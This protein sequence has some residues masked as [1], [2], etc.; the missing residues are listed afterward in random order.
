MSTRGY[1]LST[2]EPFFA[3][4]TGEDSALFDLLADTFSADQVVLTVEQDEG[5]R[6]CRVRR[7]GP[8]EP[9][10]IEFEPDQSPIPKGALEHSFAA[11]PRLSARLVLS[12]SDGRPFPAGKSRLFR[13][14]RPFVEL[15]VRQTVEAY[16]L[17][18][19]NQLLLEVCDGSDASIFLFDEKLEI[20]WANNRADELLSRQTEEVLAVSLTRDRSVELL[21]FLLETLRG[22]ASDRE[23]GPT[24]R[25]SVLLTDGSRFDLSVSPI[26]FAPAGLAGPYLL[27]VLRRAKRF[28]MAKAKPGLRRAGLS[29]REMEVVELLLIGLKNAEIAGKLFISDYTVKDHFKHIFQKLGLRTRSELVSRVLQL[30]D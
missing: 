22:I 18:R 26:S 2:G 9:P 23:A 15:A 13:D 28:E 27:V 20:V 4:P 12:R 21:G 8:A 17:E 3:G 25:G 14:L 7:V 1:A 5:K 24:D 11:S 19:E 16:H 6:L 30:A 10:R 29:K